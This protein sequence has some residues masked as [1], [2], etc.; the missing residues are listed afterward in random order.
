MLCTEWKTVPCVP[1]ARYRRRPLYQYRTDFSAPEC[2]DDGSP[3]MNLRFRDGE[4]SRRWGGSFSAENLAV[5]AG[6]TTYDV[7]TFAYIY[8]YR[9]PR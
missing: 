6:D 2:A 3:R 5:I 8:I 4:N 9:I 1:D 7:P